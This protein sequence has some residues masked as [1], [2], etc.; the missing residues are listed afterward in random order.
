M[1]H[2]W[3]FMCAWPKHP[4]AQEQAVRH[5]GPTSHQPGIR[6]PKASDGE[7]DNFKEQLQLHRRRARARPRSGDHKGHHLRVLPAVH[8]LEDWRGHVLL[9]CARAGWLPRWERADVSELVSDKTGMQ[10][11]FSL[12]Q[13]G[14]CTWHLPAM[15]PWYEGYGYGIRRYSDTLFIKKYSDT[16][17]L[18]KYWYGDIKYIL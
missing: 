3:K 8:G 15:L 11:G 4:R 7:A 1:Q 17:F 5:G 18:R 14:R 16:L 6:H 9:G 13:W 2:R 12:L 10:G